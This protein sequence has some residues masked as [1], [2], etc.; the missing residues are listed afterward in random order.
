MASS[1]PHHITREAMLIGHVFVLTLEAFP[2]D[3][4]L[5]PMWPVRPVF[6]FEKFLTHKNHRNARR[7]QQKPRSDLGSATRVPGTRVGRIRERSYPRLTVAASMVVVEQ[8]VVFNTLKDGPAGRI[9]I[10][11]VECIF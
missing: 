3:Q 5:R 7:R 11:Q 2:P 8:I 6:I 10:G 9:S 1:E 4:Q